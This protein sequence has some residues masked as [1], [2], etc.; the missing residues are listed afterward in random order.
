MRLLLSGPTGT[1]LIC[2]GL[3]ACFTACSE[4]EPPAPA[5]PLTAEEA[6]IQAGRKQ[7]RICTGCHGRDGVS[8]IASIPSLAGKPQDY[9]ATQ[10]HAFRSGERDNPTMSSIALNLDEQAIAALSHYYAS[11]P[12]AE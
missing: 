5:Q 9:L 7:A 6:L 4:G 2:A 12:A 1:R 8:R 3:L 11:L 10:L